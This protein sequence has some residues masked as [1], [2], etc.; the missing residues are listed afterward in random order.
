M[1]KAQK[2]EQR[3]SPQE[4]SSFCMQVALMME[5]GM[6]L[7]D[8]MEALVQTNHTSAYAQVYADA[9]QKLLETGTLYEALKADPHWPPY[10]VEM[11]GIGERAGKLDEVM[12]GLSVYYEREGRIRRAISSAVAYPVVLGVMLLLVVLVVLVQVLPV[13]R[14]VLG[15]MGVAMTGSGTA[16]MTV[17]TV[18]GWVVLALGLL[19]L[20]VVLV[21]LVLLRTGKRDQVQ[22]FL[23]ARFP[24][25]HH[26]SMKLSASRVASVL[27]MM[28]SSGFPLDDALDMV[29]A[30]LPDKTAAREMEKIRA[31]MAEGT[32]FGDALG[33]SALFDEI[34]GAMVRMGIAT[35]HEDQVMRKIATVYEEQVE[36]GISNLVSIIEPT[37]VAVLSVVL[38][39]ILLS[40]MLPMAGIVSSIL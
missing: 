25:V 14:R 22:Q 7:Y 30:L 17:G 35:G 38:G 24:A 37:M 31:K 2:K 21:V 23:Q 26:L 13:F 3:M 18:I 28:L 40:V 33:E 5:S 39:A 11:T 27:S 29:P 36:E 4:L 32:S 20:A 15:S 16:M 1:A 19:V 6:T 12:H 10:L 34:Y 8:G 9:N